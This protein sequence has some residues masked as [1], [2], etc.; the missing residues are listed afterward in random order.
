VNNN[1]IISPQI[2]NKTIL[3]V[4]DEPGMRSFVIDFLND[5]GYHTLEAK[6]GASA[7]KILES[8]AKIDLLFC[9]VQMPGEI[10]GYQIAEQAYKLRPQ[11]KIQ[12]TSGL[13]EATL[14]TK[15]QSSLS[16]HILHK[17]YSNIYLIK[18]IER[19]LKD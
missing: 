3:V 1:A 7:I 9:D 13:N 15:K 2:I 4:D 12:L 17:P 6:D 5:K 14:A 19:H 8:N 16:T 10:N 18:C 11:I